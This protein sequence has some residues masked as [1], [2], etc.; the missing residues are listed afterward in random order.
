M[1][2]VVYEYREPWP[3]EGALKVKAPALEGEIQVPPDS[4]RRR[5]N[6]YLARYVALALEAGE[7]MLIWGDRPYWRMSIYL[8]L[9]GFGQVARLGEIVVD[10]MTREVLQLSKEQILEMQDRADAIAS[11]LTPATRTAS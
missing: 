5:A 8:N 10:A 4:A 3:V 6:G 1:F 11:R 2:Q 9:R 7:P